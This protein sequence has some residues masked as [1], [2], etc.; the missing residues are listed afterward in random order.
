MTDEDLDALQVIKD[1][2][3]EDGSQED[4]REMM[5]AVMHF[6][7]FRIEKDLIP[8]HGT[9]E[10]TCPTCRNPIIWPNQFCQHCGQRIIDAKQRAA[11]ESSLRKNREA[12]ERKKEAKK[13]AGDE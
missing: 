1:F 2:D 8:P 4:Y 9:G 10:R 3:F 5:K 13:N 7:A 12:R 6:V 11:M